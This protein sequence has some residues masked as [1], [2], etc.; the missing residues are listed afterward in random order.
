MLKFLQ[1]NL[2][3]IMEANDPGLTSNVHRAPTQ[4]PPVPLKTYHPPPDSGTSTAY[5]V[6]LRS[7]L[8]YW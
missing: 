3:K 6:G 2:V 7:K 8:Y 4:L 1:N 5:H